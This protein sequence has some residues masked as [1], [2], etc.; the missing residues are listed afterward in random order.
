MSTVAVVVTVLMAL[1]FLGA[2]L[3]KL[4]SR[5]QSLVIRDRLGIAAGRWR[6][7]GVLELAGVTGALIGLAVRPLGIAATAGLVL[8]SIGA[9]ASHLRVRDS[10][11]DA[12]AAVVALVVSVAALVLQ[13]TT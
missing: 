9:L 1:V 11:T 13:I 5:P 7:I 10:L 4:T 8:T 2:S 12:A 6:L 3:M